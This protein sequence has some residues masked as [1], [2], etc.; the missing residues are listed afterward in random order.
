MN[1]LGNPFS[2]V[3]VCGIKEN[4]GLSLLLPE[5]YKTI[6]VAYSCFSSRQIETNK[7]ENGG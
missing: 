4:V 3:I 1:F 6:D 2:F 5:G 7:L